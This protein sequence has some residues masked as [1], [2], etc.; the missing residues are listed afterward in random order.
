MSNC[1]VVLTL[2]KVVVG[3]IKGSGEI[4]AGV[5]GTGELIGASIDAFSR[6][7]VIPLTSAFR[8][9]FV[10]GLSLVSLL[11]VIGGLI[12]TFNINRGFID[13]I[14]FGVISPLVA[15]DGV[16]GDGIARLGLDGG[17][18]TEVEIG[19]VGVAGID[20]FNVFSVWDVRRPCQER[21]NFFAR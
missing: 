14:V 20:E 7:F 2:G 21:S 9:R 5:G 17:D 16:T 3:S 1:C 11:L 6:F 15:A 10:F 8:F 19:A 18:A 4:G 13:S 12:F